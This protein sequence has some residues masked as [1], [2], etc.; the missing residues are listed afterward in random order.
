M[1]DS[2]TSVLTSEPAPAS[3]AAPAPAATP[4]VASAPPAVNAFD[5]KS[6]GISDEDIGYIQTKAYQG[7]AD[8][9]KALRGA[10][11][12]I[13]LDKIPMPRDDA[14]TEGWNRV[15]T[16]LGRPE[17]ADKYDLGKLPDNADKEYIGAMLK[18][19]HAAGASQ[20]VVSAA[21]KA[22][23]DF[24]AA[25]DATALK[26]REVRDTEQFAQLRTEWGNGYD[27]QVEH[28]RRAI[29]E[30]GIGKETLNQIESALG[31]GAMIKI[32]AG[33][34]SKFAEDTG[35]AGQGDGDPGRMTPQMALHRIEQLKADKEWVR[36][37][38][39]GN[40]SERALALKEMQQLQDA[41]FPKGT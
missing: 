4:V 39:Q 13:G 31:P 41:A 10:E 23:M 40:P 12:L 14:D 24:Q 9:L 33:F 27:T 25:R 32:F 5:W 7:P 22:Q 1:A 28:A 36:K 29:R 37:Y 15:F 34:G 26:A 35:V 20:K 6:H 8:V 38:T 21:F 3:A 30:Q 18:S 19:M 2:A 16:R 11:K 17:S